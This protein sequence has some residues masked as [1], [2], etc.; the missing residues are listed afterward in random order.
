MT[1]L[2][3]LTDAKNNESLLA[4]ALLLFLADPCSDFCLIVG[5]QNE[6]LMRSLALFYST[7]RR[8]VKGFRERKNSR[9]IFFIA[10]NLL[11][12]LSHIFFL[13]IHHV[14]KKKPLGWLWGRKKNSQWRNFGACALVVFEVS[15]CRVFPG[16]RLSLLGPRP[17]NDLG[18][19]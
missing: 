2:S 16:S 15:C 7:L 6:L 18:V 4:A 19:I 13:L 8:R 3:P 1:L 9:C 10:W 12:D 14:D 5:V 17:P 11:S